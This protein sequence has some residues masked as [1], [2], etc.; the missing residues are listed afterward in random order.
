MRF[1]TLGLHAWSIHPFTACS[2][3]QPVADMKC[4]QSELVLYIRPQG[5][6]TARLARFAQS[7]P[8]ASVRVLLDGPYGGVDMRKIEQSQHQL[9]VAGG[10]GAG[11]VLPMITAFIR[12]QQCQ[13]VGET[14]NKRGV[15]RVVLATR[16]T[17]T[18][19]WFEEAVR[20]TISNHQDRA[21]RDAEVQVDIFYTGSRDASAATNSD[22]QSTKLCDDLEKATEIKASARSVH[23]GSTSEPESSRTDVL[24]RH[25]EG[26]PDLAALVREESDS[27]TDDEQL[28][29]F[30][31]GPLSLQNDVQN[32]VAAEQ[33]TVMK[34]ARK[35]VYL[36]MEHFSWA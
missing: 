26:R 4:T 24:I 11:W 20:Q 23:G 9:V 3:P 28:G 8:E 34:G 18:A 13:S 32:A 1:F 6:F 10:S 27:M 22:G 14:R 35:Q 17:A 12:K 2:L 7:K 19:Q 21:G 15:M 31:C 29:V 25:H 5:G 30:V 33:L 16:D 36:H